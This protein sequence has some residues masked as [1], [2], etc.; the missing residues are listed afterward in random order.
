MFFWGTGPGVF[1]LNGSYDC[2]TTWF[3]KEFS[4]VHP[5]ACDLKLGPLERETL[6]DDL[7]HCPRIARVAWRRAPAPSISVPT[8]WHLRRAAA[9]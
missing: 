2:I 7:H 1:D 6:F 4:F 9:S 5:P 8:S 3:S